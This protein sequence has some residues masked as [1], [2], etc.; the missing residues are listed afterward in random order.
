M[1]VVN[2]TR[3]PAVQLDRLP[4]GLLVVLLDVRSA[5]GKIIARMNRDGF[6]ANRNN[7]MEMKRDKSSLTIIDEYGQEVL[8]VRYLNPG[9]ISLR[10][11]HIGLPPGMTNNCFMG[12]EK[13]D[14]EIRLP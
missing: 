10:G 5:N 13:A 14:F 2:S 1:Y 8:R 9:A 3:L 6:V 11:N 12:S 7:Y 4:D